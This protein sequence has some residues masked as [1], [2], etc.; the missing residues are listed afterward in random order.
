MAAWTSAGRVVTER[1][2]QIKGLFKLVEDKGFVCLNGLGGEDQE[3]SPDAVRVFC[4][5][6]L[7]NW[8]WCYH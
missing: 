5:S 7:G 4:V 3:K 2:G 1:S 8:V 6:R